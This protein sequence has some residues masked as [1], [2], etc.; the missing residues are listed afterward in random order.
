M[1]IDA[2]LIRFRRLL[3]S[4]VAVEQQRSVKLEQAAT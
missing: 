2:A 4:R 1:S 3:E